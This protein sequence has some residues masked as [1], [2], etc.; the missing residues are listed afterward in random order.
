MIAAALGAGGI[1]IYVNWKTAGCCGAHHRLVLERRNGDGVW[2]R[3]KTNIT[4]CTT[5]K[6]RV[7]QEEINGGEVWEFFRVV[8]EGVV[9]PLHYPFTAP[10][11]RP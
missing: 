10:A 11:L 3:I 5:N 1:I 9:D 6:T 4:A 7:F 2:E 8:D